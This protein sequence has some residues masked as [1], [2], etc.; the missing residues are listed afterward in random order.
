MATSTRSATPRRAAEVQRGA[1]SGERAEL[2]PLHAVEEHLEPGRVG[3]NALEQAGG[4]GLDLVLRKAGM[5]RLGERPPKAVQ[6][7][8]R[9]LQ[10]AADVCGRPLV[11]ELRALG[12]VL[13]EGVR[14]VAV[15]AQEA[16]S[17]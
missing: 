15:P 9:H 8:V 6:A 10:D 14:S 17:N 16:E 5:E 3:V 1:E 13:V 12:R 4:T 7:G 2:Y 11:E